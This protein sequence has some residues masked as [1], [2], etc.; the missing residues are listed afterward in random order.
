[1]SILNIPEYVST[2]ENSLCYPYEKTDNLK[3]VILDFICGN[4]YRK[5]SYLY[6][7]VCVRGKES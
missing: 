2:K 7:M 6:I 5:P 3:F 4:T 1:M